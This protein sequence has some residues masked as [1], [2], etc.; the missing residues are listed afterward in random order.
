MDNPSIKKSLEA[1]CTI[2]DKIADSDIRKAFDMLFNLVEVL[3]SENEKHLKTIQKQQD[4]INHLKGEQGKP[5]IRPQKGDDNH[6]SEDDR[7]KREKKQKKKPRK[8]KQ[9][10]VKVDRTVT[11]TI[12]RDMLPPDAERKGYKPIV[13]QGKP[14]ATDPLTNTFIQM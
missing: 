6:S 12:D 7:K 1:I 11:C 13:I 3:V 2:A 5:K 8:K 4:E 10:T 14:S 9:D